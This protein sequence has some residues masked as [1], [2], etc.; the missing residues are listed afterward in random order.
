MHYL[1][2]SKEV[3][4]DVLSCTNLSVV[5]QAELVLENFVIM[6]NKIRKESSFADLKLNVSEEIKSLTGIKAP[7]K[8]KKLISDIQ[9]GSKANLDPEVYSRIKELIQNPSSYDSSCYVELKKSEITTAP[10]NISYQDDEVIRVKLTLF[11]EKLIRNIKDRFSEDGDLELGIQE[12]KSEIFKIKNT[13]K[14]TT[15]W[16]T[17]LNAIM[18]YKSSLALMGR[19][20]NNLPELKRKLE[21]VNIFKKQYLSDF[22]PKDEVIHKLEMKYSMSRDDYSLSEILGAHINNLWDYD[23][24]NE[25]LGTS[26]SEYQMLLEMYELQCL[27]FL[28]I[29]VTSNQFEKEILN[30][31]NYQENDN[32]NGDILENENIRFLVQTLTPIIEGEIK[33]L[34]EV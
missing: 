6:W 10:S 8:L 28:G 20:E 16:G 27:G 18:G 4:L 29:W 2:C 33:Y 21:E 24:I 17:T 11:Q 12:I 26:I 14:T 9:K 31:L 22:N 30:S 3:L 7:V 15:L 1:M 32:L 5:R 34:Q 19:I 25:M 13:F 23:T